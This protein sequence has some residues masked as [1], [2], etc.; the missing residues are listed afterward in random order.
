MATILVL[1]DSPD[2]SALLV[3]LLGYLGH[4]SLECANAEQALA[5]VATERPDLVIAVVSQLL[6]L[7]RLEAG[8]VELELIELRAGDVARLA[9]DALAASAQAKTISTQLIV[10][11]GEML[12]LADWTKLLQIFTN[13]LSN[14]I[15]FTP[16]GGHVTVKVESE[17]GAVSVRVIDTGLGIPADQLPHLFEQF[18]QV[19]K[20]GTAGERGS[21]LGLSIVR[22]LVELHG[23]TLEVTSGE[24]RGTTFT[25]R[26]P[27]V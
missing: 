17:P 11:A 12:V 14:A 2:N 16:A 23:G 27:A 5:V 6:D 9:L 20:Q 3:M 22:Q 19:H 18:R 7:A 21:G 13:L 25:V 8:K 4:T 24:S 10:E 26:L 1:D 15:K